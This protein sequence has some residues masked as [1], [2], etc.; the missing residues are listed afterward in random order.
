[1]GEYKNGKFNLIVSL[2]FNSSN[3]RFQKE[4]QLLCDF[5]QRVSNDLYVATA[6]KHAIGTLKVAK[7]GRASKVSDIWFNDYGAT[8]ATAARL[9]NLPE[10]MDYALDDMPFPGVMLHELGHYLYDLR[11]E[12]YYPE[13]DQ[14]AGLLGCLPFNE[15]LRQKT[16]LMQWLGW[17]YF[18]HWAK[19]TL[20]G[21]TR[22]YRF[23]EFNQFFDDHR[24]GAG[25]AGLMSQTTF[26]E[27]RIIRFCHEGNHNKEAENKQNEEHNKLSCWACMA[28]NSKHGGKDYQLRESDGRA[29]LPSAPFPRI[30]CSELPYSEEYALAID[31]QFADDDGEGEAEGN[32][33]RRAVLT[34]LTFWTDHLRTA[35]ALSLM[36]LSG[37]EE[38]RLGPLDLTKSLE[39]VNKLRNQV[40]KNIETGLGNLR[41]SINDADDRGK[42]VT[43]IE[44]TLQE[45]LKRFKGDQKQ[46]SN[47][48]LV[49]LIRNPVSYDAKALREVIDEIVGWAVRVYIIGLGEQ[50]NP[51]LLN[52][53]ATTTGG[54]YFGTNAGLKELDGFF[55]MIDSLLWIIGSSRENGGVTS[56]R[57][58]NGSRTGKDRLRSSRFR[59]IS[60]GWQ[61]VAH[62][63]NYF[64]PWSVLRKSFDFPVHITEGSDQCTLGVLWTGKEVVGK[65]FDM[66]LFDPKGDPVE[67]SIQNWTERAEEP[68]RFFSV[69]KP[70]GGKW[71]IRV[72]GSGIT[73]SMFKSIGFEV[74]REIRLECSAVRPIIRAGEKIQLKVRMLY[75][76]PLTKL[77]ISATVE[78][79]N[80]DYDHFELVSKPGTAHHDGFHLL[81]Y[82]TSKE[83]LG[84]YLIKVGVYRRGSEEKFPM[85]PQ[86]F[87]RPGIQK[88]RRYVR[89]EVPEINREHRLTV[90]A[91]SSKT[92][93]ENLNVFELENVSLKKEKNI[94]GRKGIIKKP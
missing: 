25:G 39:D 9:W 61:P 30:V 60:L 86:H 66:E 58:I 28:D 90:V 56:F 32:V 69:V 51:A 63:V 21:R 57:E 88:N 27:G 74:N 62:N 79:P 33:Q 64:N 24:P 65:V 83:G 49:L 72:S 91:I 3:S 29:A 38:W 17:Q 82:Q 26:V 42:G 13:D 67:K 45:G 23:R 76:V 70:A 44:D 12:Y 19:K 93:W 1:M 92:K 6:G 40:R 85:S 78:L 89:A 43:Y 7:N 81:E 71:T 18:S 52:H 55:F 15:A 31:G 37:T 8:Y 75:K 2:R 16:S 84:C 10:S 5:F 14:S 41:K 94:M 80:G 48:V 36:S 11:D 47:Q 34:G 68:Y 22:L 53:I 73:S 77:Q 50:Q 46:V 4:L 87:T 35:E 59:K 20:N 54:S